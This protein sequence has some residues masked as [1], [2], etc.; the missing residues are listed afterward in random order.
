[1][2]LNDVADILAGKSDYYYLIS[3]T[4]DVDK[5]DYMARDSYLQAY[6]TV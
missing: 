4:I 3:S 6:L 5:L 2:G 1:M